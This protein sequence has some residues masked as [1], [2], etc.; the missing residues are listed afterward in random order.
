[1]LACGDAEIAKILHDDMCA[2][3]RPARRHAWIFIMNGHAMRS[4]GTLRQC[5]LESTRCNVSWCIQLK[6]DHRCSCRP[7]IS[8]IKAFRKFQ[9]C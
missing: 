7:S 9:G 4:Y 1:M 6:E 5:R 3:G 8:S 2:A